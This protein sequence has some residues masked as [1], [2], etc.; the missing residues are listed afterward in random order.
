MNLLID[1]LDRIQW[2]KLRSQL[3]NA[4]NVPLYFPRMIFAISET[5]GL[6]AYWQ[7]DNYVVVQS[8]LFEAA[9]YLVPFLLSGL[10]IGT[11]FGKHMCLDLIAEIAGGFPD[12]TEINSG[13]AAIEFRCGDEIRKG[14]PLFYSFL[15][16]ED[17]RIR[18]CAI[19]IL[20][21]VE[22]DKQRLNWYFQKLL[23]L[24]LRDIAREFVE[25]KLLKPN[26]T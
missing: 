16:S 18:E 12:T 21:W 25:K 5:Q 17:F 20:A 1:E 22:R 14:L 9:E 23:Q 19:T 24:G 4:I 2:G 26:D 15:E 3:G 11:P 8:Q 7:L 6:E 10:V 13:N